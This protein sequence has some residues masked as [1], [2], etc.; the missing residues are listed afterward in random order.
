MLIKNSPTLKSASIVYANSNN[1]LKPVHNKT[2][3]KVWG[4]WDVG[5]PH[6]YPR[7]ARED[8]WLK[9]YTISQNVMAWQVSQVS[10]LT[11]DYQTFKFTFCG[12]QNTC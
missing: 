3:D 5:I 6:L 12:I 1:L 2:I 7:G 10:T 8:P 9:Q 11:L 4:G